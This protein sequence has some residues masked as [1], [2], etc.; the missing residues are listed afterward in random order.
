MST[1]PST[2]YVL[3]NEDDFVEAVTDDQDEALDNT[4]W[5]SIKYDSYYY[6]ETYVLKED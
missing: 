3:F 6:F 1:A 2:L 4:E 5:L